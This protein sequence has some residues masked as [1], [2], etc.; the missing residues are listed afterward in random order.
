MKDSRP[1]AEPI[2]KTCPHC[3]AYVEFY[4]KNLPHNPQEP[5]RGRCKLC[6][7]SWTMKEFESA[8][9]GKRLSK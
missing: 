7:Q 5:W 8:I 6:G 4:V 3:G 1:S 9:S 2:L